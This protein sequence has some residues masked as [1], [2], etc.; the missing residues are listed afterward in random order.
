M[1][2]YQYNLPLLIT[3][4]EDEAALD[5]FVRDTFHFDIIRERNFELTDTLFNPLRGKEEK[6]AL[7]E[8]V[9]II[10]FAEYFYNFLKQLIDNGDIIYYEKIRD[11]FL[12]KLSVM[13]HCLYAKVTTAIPL[14]D[15]QMDRIT[16]KLEEFFG[17]Q[18]FVYNNVSHHFSAGLLIQCGDQMIDLEV[19]TAFDQLKARLGVAQAAL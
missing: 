12:E 18:V 14:S 10:Y 8:E 5:S 4:L 1:Q 13:Q 9:L 3:I 2:N 6:L 11:S 16:T 7:L 15:T 17:Q 19:R